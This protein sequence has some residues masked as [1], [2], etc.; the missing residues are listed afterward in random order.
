[1]VVG[2]SELV[3]GRR[4]LWL[5]WALVA[6]VAGGVASE[7]ARRVGFP[8]RWRGVVDWRGW[9]GSGS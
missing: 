2:S 9:P 3:G 1:V 7:V 8:H 4:L 5:A 6:V